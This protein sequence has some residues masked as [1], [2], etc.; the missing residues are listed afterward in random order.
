MIKNNFDFTSSKWFWFG[1]SFSIY[2]ILLYLRELPCYDI[3]Y[4]TFKL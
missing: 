2:E 4:R 3:F 1:Y